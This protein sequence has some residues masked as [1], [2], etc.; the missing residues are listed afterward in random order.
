MQSLI[1]AFQDTSMFSHVLFV[2]DSH[3]SQDQLPVQ[4]FCSNREQHHQKL[5]CGA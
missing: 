1:S 5:E 3:A 4:V 2:V